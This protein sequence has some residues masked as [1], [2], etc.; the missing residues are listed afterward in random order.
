M[1]VENH[2]I[3]TFEYSFNP[4]TDC[5][6]KGPTAELTLNE[7]ED[8]GIREVLE[9]PGAALGSWAFLDALLEPSGTGSPFVFKE[10]LGQAR[11]VKVALSGLFGRFVARAYLERYFKLS[12]FAHLGRQTL[13]LDGKRQVEVRRKPNKRGDLPDWLA[14][15]SQLSKL[16]IAEAKGCHDK[17]GAQKSLDRAWEQANRIEIV[18]QGKRA[19]VKRIAIATR[20]GAANGGAATPI[21]AVRDPDEHGDLPDGDMEAAL[22]GVARLHVANLVQGLGYSE[23][24]T[25]L[26]GIVNA[27]AGSF[28]VRA[29]ANARSALDS[30]PLSGLPDAAEVEF[31]GALL[32]RWV[33][34]AGPLREATLSA[35]D[36]VTLRRMDL[37][38]VFVGLERRVV[39]AAIEGDAAK[40][41]EVGSRA[42][43]SDG[44]VRTD[45]AGGWMVRPIHGDQDFSS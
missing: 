22:I 7:I 11:E 33:T 40:I 29:A 8:A 31:A 28:S 37:R 26:H 30:A 25:A 19:N 15:D 36:Q 43:R 3:R 2:V 45:G 20:W 10:P 17:S 13:M 6:I 32:G 44:A 12:H 27:A 24:S 21:L 38:P 35:A 4:E 18:S 16:T 23:L 9:T 41:K 39:T 5:P 34:R 42:R 14:C 1:G